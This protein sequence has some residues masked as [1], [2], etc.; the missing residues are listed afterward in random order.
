MQNNYY[1]IDLWGNELYAKKYVYVGDYKD[2]IACVCLYEGCFKHIDSQGNY[3]ND[4]HF[5]D[6]GIFHKNFATARDSEGWFHINKK[7]EALYNER[8]LYVEPFYNGY[9]LVTTFE[10]KKKII[11][12]K[13]KIS[14][15][16]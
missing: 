8:Y 4:K 5:I 12:E 14:L 1:H 7:G 3:I 10:Y 16:I 2:G 15:T 6:I 9:A 13:G 11:D